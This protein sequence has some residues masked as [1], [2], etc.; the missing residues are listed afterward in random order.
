LEP[1]ISLLTLGTLDL[2]RAIR[3]YRD[4]L[5]WP[6][7]SAGGGEAA[8]FRTG[9]AILALY[10]RHLL[11][12]DARLD[13]AGSGFGGI[14]L[15]HNVRSREEVDAVLAEAVAAGGTLLKA[16]R[17]ADWG[18]YSGYFADPDGFPWEVAWNPGFPLAEDGSLH[19]P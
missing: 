19:L 17:T 14:T 5:G 18:G 13:A 10:P 1:R 11:A 6:M 2:A 8:F 12:T 9:G 16:A 15:A 7:S 3:F 4:G